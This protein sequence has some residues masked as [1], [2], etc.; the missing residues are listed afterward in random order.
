[1]SKSQNLSKL[2]ASLARV[3][4][5][6]ALLAN[7]T[8]FAQNKPSPP[9]DTPATA[10]PLAHDLSPAVTR[11]AIGKAMQRV[12]DWQIARL[13]PQ[14]QTDWTFGALYPGLLAV[15][16]QVGAGKYRQAVLDLSRRLDFKPGPRVLHADDQ[17]V[18]QSYLELYAQAHDPAMLVPTRERMDQEKAT[19]D[20]ADKPLWW[21][22]DALFMAPPVLAELSRTTGDPSYDTFM[23][24]EWAVTSSLLYDPNDHLFSRDATFLDKHEKNGRKVYWAR[25]NGWVMGGLVRVIDRLPANSPDRARYVRQ[26][27]EMAAALLPLQGKDGLWRP[28]LLDPEAYPLPEVSGS[29]FITYAFSYGVHHGLLP[30]RT[31]EPAVRRA[32]AGAVAHIYED[33]R[34]GCIQPVGSSPAAFSETSSYVYGVGA[35]LLAGSEIY[36]NAH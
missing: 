1:M 6:L 34:L 28:G 31:Y 25:G 4:L 16:P 10:G 35:F 15:P 20:D 2:T 3:L 23:N 26:L 9:G 27:Q 7:T 19:P 8:S 5:P 36:R 24:H 32:W 22:C 21:W 13:P 30:A 14:P 17:A 33:G 29:M 18:S 11:Q 12:A